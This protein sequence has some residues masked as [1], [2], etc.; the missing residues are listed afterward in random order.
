MR[1]TV[2]LTAALFLVACNMAGKDIT[3]AEYNSHMRV[4]FWEVH[5]R[6]KLGGSEVVI[7]A[8]SKERERRLVSEAVAIMN[9]ALPSCAQLKMGN[10]DEL[11]SFK[12]H[13][14]IKNNHQT[15]LPN[16]V[17]VKP[18]TL[19]IEFVSTGYRAG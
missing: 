3:V 15:T 10:P 5:D 19:Y 11:V 2:A 6:N 18:K 16:N 9:E 4:P 13:V 17:A 14:K 1:T 12:H 8:D 7:V